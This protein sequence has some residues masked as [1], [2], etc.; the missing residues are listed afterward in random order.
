MKRLSESQL[1]CLAVQSEEVPTAERNLCGKGSDEIT[2][3]YNLYELLK[4]A[5]ELLNACPSDDQKLKQMAKH[6][7][8]SQG[9]VGKFSAEIYVKAFFKVAM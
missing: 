8:Q 7:I 3:K 5:R 9:W 1:N 4:K 6:L 2:A